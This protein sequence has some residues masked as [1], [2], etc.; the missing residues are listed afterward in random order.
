MGM[1][2]AIVARA[3]VPMKFRR[4]D[5]DLPEIMAW[6]VKSEHEGAM[7]HGVPGVGKSMTMGLLVRDWARAWARKEINPGGVPVFDMWRWID[8]TSFT[9]RIQDAFKNGDGEETAYRILK[10]ISEVPRLVIDDLGVEKGTQFVVQATYYLLDQREKW[11][12]P[13]FITTNV[14]LDE[15]DAQYGARITDRIA[16]TCRV[17]YLK[18]ASRRMK[19]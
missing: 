2:P 3:G 15:L 11:L 10:R 17:L 1:V 13:T 6:A 9:M 8:Y 4:D 19:S 14:P 18:G 5:L 7:L 12:R 16:G